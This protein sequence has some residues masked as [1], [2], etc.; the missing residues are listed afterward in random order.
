MGCFAMRLERLRVPL[1]IPPM[2]LRGIVPVS[3][4]RIPGRDLFGNGTCNG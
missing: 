2:F 1:Q 4:S 3:P